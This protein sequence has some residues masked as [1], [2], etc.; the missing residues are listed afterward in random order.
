MQIDKKKLLLKDLPSIRQMLAFVSVYELGHMSAAAE[1]LS[2]TQPAVTVLIKELE[3]TLG[4]KL[5]DRAT[6]TLKPTE[7]AEAILPFI[8]R[9]LS[10][11]N[12]MNQHLKQLKNLAIGHLRVAVTP[13]STQ[14]LLPILLQEF[15]FQH[16]DIDIHIE[17]CKPLQLISALLNEKAEIAIGV[18]ESDIPGIMK[19]KIFE[20]NLVAV[21][22]HDYLPM[23]TTLD[24]HT[25]TQYPLLLTQIGYGIR[26]Q[27]EKA[28]NAIFPEKK[29][30]IAHES[31]L[32]STVVALAKSGLGIGIVPTS[33]VRDMQHLLQVKALTQPKLSREIS[34]L[35]LKDKALSPS[36]EALLQLS[37]R[38]DWAVEETGS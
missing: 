32:I 18:L 21:C 2:L 12:E 26:D 10:E 20:D 23:G 14:F 28:F 16:P 38:V 24:W 30:Q 4:V 13:S 8:L 11:L 7:A 33:A 5:F 3:N 34:L 36:A 37:Q 6:R 15:K 27:F 31:T 17:E 9:S 29:L 35:Y 1:E 19:H 22:R 25:L